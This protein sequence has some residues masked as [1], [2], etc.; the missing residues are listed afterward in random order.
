MNI[1]VQI[2]QDEM[3]KVVADGVVGLLSDGSREPYQVISDAIRDGVA[4]AISEKLSKRWGED[5]IDEIAERVAK[6]TAL[7]AK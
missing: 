2:P 6:A 5:L 1:T 4:K 7:P 3:I